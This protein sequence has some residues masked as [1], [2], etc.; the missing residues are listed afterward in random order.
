[1][2]YK[3]INQIYGDGLWEIGLPSCERL[4][5]DETFLNNIPKLSINKFEIF[6]FET[7]LNI[8]RPSFWVK[9]TFG[10]YIL[11]VAICAKKYDDIRYITDKGHK[12]RISYVTFPKELKNGDKVGLNVKSQV[13]RR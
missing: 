4:I 12:I 2:D 5:I 11:V 1:M 9:D 6:M 8:Y 13:V 10:D 7:M 3:V